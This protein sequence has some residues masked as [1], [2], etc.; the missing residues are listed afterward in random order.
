[1]R[2]PKTIK[3]TALEDDLAINP[4]NRNTLNVPTSDINPCTDETVALVLSSM[5]CCSLASNITLSNCRSLFE[6]IGG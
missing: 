6:S 4:N 1:M 3:G 5:T 2:I